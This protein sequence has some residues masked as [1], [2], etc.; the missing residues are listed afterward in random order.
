[1]NKRKIVELKNFPFKPLYALKI[2]CCVLNSISILSKLKLAR[3]MRISRTSIQSNFY[4]RKRHSAKN[5]ES[6]RALRHVGNVLYY[7]EQSPRNSKK[8][9]E[10]VALFS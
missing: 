5:F 10:D 8:K 1:M 7:G 2:L 6:C 9:V 4:F 3:V